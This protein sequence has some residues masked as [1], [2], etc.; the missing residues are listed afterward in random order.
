M[1]RIETIQGNLIANVPKLHYVKK[2]GDN[3]VSTSFLTAEAIM[4][5]GQVY[6]IAGYPSAGDFVTVNIL[7][8]NDTEKINHK[9]FNLSFL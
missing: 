1:Y 3:F 5:N 4:F 8:Y 7:E 6:N 9:Y 2:D